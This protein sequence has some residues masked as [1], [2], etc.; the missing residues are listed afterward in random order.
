MSPNV[1]AEGPTTAATLPRGRDARMSVRNP[2]TASS[3]PTSTH[4]ASF[5]RRKATYTSSS[6][7]SA[8]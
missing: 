2:A 5:C 1:R 8:A 3:E 4:G 6:S 7:M